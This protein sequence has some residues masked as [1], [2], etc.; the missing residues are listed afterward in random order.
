MTFW[1]TNARV[2]TLAGPRRRRGK[3]FGD[4]RVIE[5]G[6]VAMEQGRIV[7]VTE[8]AVGKSFFDAQ[9]RV[10]LPGFVDCHTHACWAGSRLD[11]WGRS[12]R[13]EPYLDI[14]AKG[15]GI[16]STVR[17]VREAGENALALALTERLNAML[18]HGTTT[19][20]VKS[21]YGLT[22]A[23]ELKMLR[24]IASAARNWRGSGVVSTALIAH[25]IDREQPDF[26]QKTIEETLP[27]VHAAFPGVTIDA[28]CENGAWSLDDCAQL[29]EH[30][31]ALGH[32][33]RV[34]ADQFNS[35]G[36]VEWALAH[37]AVSVDHL[38][39][40]G[41]ATIGALAAPDTFGVL[42]PCS[43]FHT[44][45]RFAPGRA[46]VDAGALVAIA[47]NFNPGSAPTGSM[48]MAMALAVRR[49]GLTPEEAIAAATV[50]GAEV[51]GL[52]DRGQI[53]PGQR[54]DLVL[55]DC[56]DERAIAWMFGMNGVHAVWVGGAQVVGPR[57]PV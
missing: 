14:L 40:S 29:F 43:G 23:D 2:V 24:S 19:V 17:A 15:G 12:L 20:E 10:L 7:E 34:H 26:A 11:E 56:F 53:V 32:P 22:T 57:Q 51:L 16:M 44:D 31:K 18:A 50:H 3:A 9:G 28:Y 5:R 48:P 41:D 30:A 6:N 46:L 13:G 27:A 4:L 55:M 45:Q 1:I 38:E 25:A 36:M 49:N 39:A 47:T 37:C 8:T 33:F 54:A 52:H 42:L 21:G 35:L